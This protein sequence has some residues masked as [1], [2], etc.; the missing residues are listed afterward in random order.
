MI[1]KILLLAIIVFFLILFSY[2]FFIRFY[3]LNDFK[4]TRLYLG[5][6]DNIDELVYQ[7][8]NSSKKCFE[9]FYTNKEAQI[10]II[11]F[12]KKEIYKFEKNYSFINRIKIQKDSF[13]L[14]YYHKIF[15]KTID[16]YYI[17]CDLLTNL[18]K[19]CAKYQN[20]DLFYNVFKYF[21]YRTSPVFQY[22]SNIDVP[23]NYAAF[24]TFTKY[25]NKIIIYV[26]V[27]V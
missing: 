4:H 10:D 19:F 23:I 1:L 9:V 17:S 21:I 22:N 15:G 5:N 13:L 24:K 16:T 7:P 14:K 26:I 3:D 6:R 20:M 18:F 11:R 27:D 8:I 12:M 25:Y 2:E